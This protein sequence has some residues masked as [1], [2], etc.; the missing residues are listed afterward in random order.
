[1]KVVA[2]IQ[3]RM[4]SSRLPGKVLVDLC[5][6]PVLHWVCDRVGRTAGVDRVV[7]ATSDRAGD[8]RIAELCHAL[9]VAVV[10]GSERDVLGRFRLAAEQHAADVVVRVTGDCPLLD[11][12]VSGEV[13]ALLSGSSY[14]YA[15]NVH[16]RRFPR[17]LDTEAFTVGALRAAADE[18]DH[19]SDR[20]HVT[21]Y[22]LTHPDR[23]SAGAVVADAD[24][25]QHRWTRPKTSRSCA[26]CANA[27][28]RGL[29]GRTCWR[30]SS[31]TRR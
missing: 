7:V 24:Y 8:D 11:P 23:F 30:S 14:Q 21:P 12:V 3:A 15:S 6:R 20:E 16:P 10:R 5:G 26:R 28:R 25:S 4:G 13:I 1:M 27:C 17:G 2:I 29:R 31:V 18:A 19:P 22:L 9:G